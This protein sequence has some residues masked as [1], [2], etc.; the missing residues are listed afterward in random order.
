M[1]FAVNYKDNNTANIKNKDG[2]VFSDEYHAKDSGT[3][4]Y[5][6][7][8]ILNASSKIGLDLQNHAGGLTDGRYN[9]KIN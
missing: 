7:D 1:L 8:L 5:Y 9:E 6:L 3:P 4:Q 2:V